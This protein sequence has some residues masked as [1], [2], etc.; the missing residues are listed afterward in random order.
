MK[1]EVKV[2]NGYVV[3]NN[4]TVGSVSRVKNGTYTAKIEMGTAVWADYPI[5]DI[6]CVYYDVSDN[7]SSIAVEKY[8]KAHVE[9]IAL[10]YG[11]YSRAPKIEAEKAFKITIINDKGRKLGGFFVSQRQKNQYNGF[12]EK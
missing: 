11:I 10:S 2:F 1:R 4:V 6:D 12:L 8:I 7:L 3:L 5:G 9:D